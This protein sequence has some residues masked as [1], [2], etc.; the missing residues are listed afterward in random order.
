[1]SNSNNKS[2]SIKEILNLTDKNGHSLNSEWKQYYDAYS[3]DRP[4]EQIKILKSII[5]LS[6]KYR[7]SFDFWDASILYVK[8][9]VEINW[10]SRDSV[11]KE[12]EN[13][14]LN[15]DEPIITFFYKKDLKFENE[16]TLFSY[17][18]S[19]KDRLRNS[20]NSV[21]YEYKGSI[22]DKMS[23]TLPSFIKNDYEYLLWIL[24]FQ[25]NYNTSEVGSNIVYKTLSEELSK[26]YPESAYLEF[27]TISNENNREK[28]QNLMQSFADKYDGT[29][30][31]YYALSEILKM[32]KEHLDESDSNNE[33]L[34]KK[35]YKDCENFEKSRKSFRGKFGF[36]SK[37]IETVKSL[38]KEMRKSSINVKVVDKNVLISFKNLNEANIEICR[39][40]G[41]SKEFVFQKKIR[42]T[43]NSFYVVDLVSVPLPEM[44]DGQYFIKVYEK[45]IKAST[46]VLKYRLSI[47][48]REE[49]R[50]I[51]IY[52]ADYISGKPLQKVDLFLTKNG[53]TVRSVTN[54]H[55][56]DGFNILPKTISSGIKDLSLYCLYALAKDPS[57]YTLLSSDISLDTDYCDNNYLDDYYLD[58]KDKSCNIFLDRKAYNPGDS[59]C[60]KAIFYRLNQIDNR[61]VKNSGEKVEVIFY[62][63][64]HKELQKLDLVTN[65]FGSVA[66]NFKIPLG[67][68]NGEFSISVKCGKNYFA[69]ESF[70]VDDFVPPTY[71]LDFE[72]LKTLYVP[73][74]KV[75][76]KGQIN[77]FSGHSLTDAKLF[78]TVTCKD[79]IYSKGSFSISTDGKFSLTFNTPSENY[80]QDI[81]VNVKIT[82]NT[83]ETNEYNKSIVITKRI[84]VKLYILNGVESEIDL[85]PSFVFPDNFSRY[86]NTYFLGDQEAKFIMKI[87]DI[88]GNTVAGK[89]KYS[90]YDEK[91]TELKTG[92]ANSGDKC[93]VNLSGMKDGLYWVKAISTYK[94]ENDSII[95]K[96]E[97]RVVFIKLSPSAV[98]LDAPIDK[99]IYCPEYNIDP[100]KDI[101]VKIASTTGN[102]W[103]VAEI[104]G[105]NKEVLDSKLIY[106]EGKRGER[107][108]VE[109][110]SF[111]YKEEYPDKI[112][113][114]IFYFKNSSYTDWSHSISRTKPRSELK[115]CFDSFVDKALPDT[116]YTFKLRTAPNV[117]CVVSVYDKSLDCIATNKWK[118]I[119][120]Y[121][122]SSDC[123]SV[124]AQPGEI[125][126]YCESDYLCEFGSMCDDP[127]LMSRSEDKSIDE[128]STPAINT[129]STDIYI[130][131]NFANTLTFQ[132]FLHSNADSTVTFKFRTSDKLS[133][134]HVQ[135][136]AH[137]K[138]MNNN[139]LSKEI[140]V[141]MP[142]KVEIL[143]PKYLYAGDKCKLSVTVSNNSDLAVSGKL[144]LYQYNT[145]EYKTTNPIS[146]KVITLTVP[147]K[148]VKKEIFEITVPEKLDIDKIVGIKAA[149]KDSEN[150]F[151][152]GLFTPITIKPN[153]QTLTE[154]HSAALLPGMNREQ[155]IDKIKSSFVNISQSGAEI[156]EISILDMIKSSLPTSI[157]PKH[158]DCLS[159]S[160][161]YYSRIIAEKIGVKVKDDGTTEQL[162]V[163]ILKCR[164]ADGGFGWFE[165]MPS[166]PIV[167]AVILERF[168]KLRNAGLIDISELKLG[169]SVNFLDRTI[170]E[171]EKPFWCGG[172]SIEQYLYIRSYYADIKFNINEIS[173]YSNSKER[174]KQFKEYTKDYLIPSNERGL[175][176]YILEKAR[177]VMTL[178]NLS[179]TS[180]GLSLAQSF[181]LNLGI[182]EKLE[183][184]LSLDIVSL[185]E[186]AVNHNNG[187]I[188]FPNAVLPFRGLLESEAYAHSM[189]C[190]L[191]TIY[192]TKG[193]VNR[194]LSAEASK[195]ADGIRIWL[196]LQKETQKW[197]EDEPA[198]VDA[199]NSILSGTDAV[200]S[201]K[202]IIAKK[203][204]TKPFKDI[205]SSG[206]GIKIERKIYRESTSVDS[207]DGK[208]KVSYEPINDGTKL[209]IGDK[210][211]IDYIINNEENRSFVRL[212]ANRESTLRPINQL[213]GLYGCGIRPLYI[214]DWYLFTPNGYMDVKTDRTEYY[215][216]S[217][218][219]E[220]T[221]ISEEFFVIQQGVFHA[222]VLEIESMYAPHYRA[223]SAFSGSLKVL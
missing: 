46:T 65:D 121:S 105:D 69:T 134:Y 86:D 76:V 115:L 79:N 85:D 199:V 151:S 75:V 74:D 108:S 198:F 34:Y 32:R 186:Y 172:L 112:Y 35:L 43:K 31:S 72:P 63:S 156:E 222:P 146:E 10:K 52:V 59:V 38:M 220:K 103:A 166:S 129:N 135:I 73:G 55:L 139:V 111:K 23:G 8:R 28:R 206:N 110:V 171:V 191:F 179:S 119:S 71:S 83:G 60:F 196:M 187:G 202:V 62:D 100:G 204:Y 194:S 122:S 174:W 47:A 118:P 178:T 138:T 161:A 211:R 16:A 192:A 45:R 153:I 12:L 159:I 98:S 5:E 137:D 27:I 190:D 30:I 89:I 195:V 208:E 67:L 207:T 54:F 99:I 48:M 216:D 183:K 176:G 210:I 25:K 82:N 49:K 51:G 219:E 1:M 212:I 84:N 29:S 126:E 90:L 213:S 180:A 120:L 127:V 182:K 37:K 107:G 26:R 201:T 97:C 184:S 131:D 19:E 109:D 218:P 197:N 124:D 42:N 142:V 147:S 128:Y 170:L 36:I 3:A 13:N 123:I 155:L 64:E 133:T 15:F 2:F 132:P 214:N 78:Y 169:E 223:N 144:F 95:T 145:K 167:T 163:K 209:N 200:K 116:E 114:H 87:T 143:E 221:V 56:E 11:Y 189:L 181:G 9:S 41:K 6:K 20:K 140:E 39:K 168:A 61:R 93:V 14:V 141:T 94:D 149:F 104:I 102:I 188:Y 22:A 58:D 157:K 175:N 160:E 7:I 125:Y 96:D 21:F 88:D 130:R 152:D 113:I 136:F 154:I 24:F 106:L 44:D 203:T 57:G 92:M 150:K 177:R 91:G 4:Q 162:I 50:G 217:F 158:N 185:L 66:G 80:Y 68:R 165:G 101:N 77:S 81:N 70:R 117:E 17:I 148:G 33:L 18:F 173:G 40:N 215:F 205:L 193:G 164:N 53:K